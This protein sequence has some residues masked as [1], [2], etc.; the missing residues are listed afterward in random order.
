[1]TRHV[2]THCQARTISS[3]LSNICRRRID[4]LN[5]S[6]WS[7]ICEE[8]MF[9][10]SRPCHEHELTEF[11]QTNS[12]WSKLVRGKLFPCDPCTV[13]SRR[14]RTQPGWCTTRW[15]AVEAEAARGCPQRAD[16]AKRTARRS[17]PTHAADAARTQSPAPPPSCP[18]P[19]VRT[20]SAA[21]QGPPSAHGS[22]SC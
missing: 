18:R 4:S 14:K 22:K 7:S 2:G 15:M 20:P 10:S 6:A 9:L 11:G 3:I 13:P 12:V 5:L 16:S 21:A 19:A 8:G 17:P 1:M